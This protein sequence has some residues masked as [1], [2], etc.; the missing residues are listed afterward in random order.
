[1]QF[2]TEKI[3]KGCAPW[4]FHLKNQV[5]LLK[6]MLS[7]ALSSS[8]FF[9]CLYHD[10]ESIRL[11][12]CAHHLDHGLNSQNPWISRQI[13]PVA[14]YTFFMSP[15]PSCC[16]KSGSFHPWLHFCD[17]RDGPKVTVC[18]GVDGTWVYGRENY[19]HVHKAFNDVGWNQKEIR[20]FASCKTQARGLG[21]QAMIFWLEVQEIRNLIRA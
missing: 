21:S 2:L 16:S 1:M 11:R 9:L 6:L 8:V 7:L 18:K 17:P 19:K 4:H 3:I 20:M 10:A 13:T 15:F 12:G 5:A 14:T